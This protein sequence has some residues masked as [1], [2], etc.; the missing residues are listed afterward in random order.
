MSLVL[1]EHPDPG[2]YRVVQYV[3]RWLVVREVPGTDTLAV[4]ADCRT[5]SAANV[6]AEDFSQ[7]R[8]TT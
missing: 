6:V 3:D 5:E 7:V 2:A 1:A 4:V 8:Q